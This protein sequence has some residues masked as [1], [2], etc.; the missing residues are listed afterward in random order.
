MTYTETDVL[1]HLAHSDGDK[2]QHDHLIDESV[3]RDAAA[4]TGVPI[5]DVRVIFEYAREAMGHKS[6]R[7]ALDIRD[8]LA[9]ILAAPNPVNAAW[10]IGFAMG[11]DACEG[12]SIDDVATEL[13]KKD[14]PV[15]RAGISKAAQEFGTMFNLPTSRYQRGEAA[16]DA[17]AESATKVHHAKDDATRPRQLPKQIPQNLFAALVERGVS[18]TPTSMNIPDDANDET[19]EMCWGLVGFIQR[20]NQW[21]I[22]D[23]ARATKERRRETWEKYADRVGI[24]PH[25]AEQLAYVSEAV[26]ASVRTEALTFAHHERVAP[27]LPDQQRHWLQQAV[28]HNLTVRQLRNSIKAGKIVLATRVAPHGIDSIESWTGALMVNWERNIFNKR[29]DK[30][31][32]ETLVRWLDKLRKPHQMYESIY[33]RIHNKKP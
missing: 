24:A 27:L 9:F 19:L 32:K 16:Q 22:G 15:T 5:D 13:I 14:L 18:F 2:Q 11:L 23:T 31:P 30:A 29:F 33:M 25:Y 8:G 21:F 6:G 17:Y 1:D 3:L 4:E 28:E 12:R 20:T 7:D 26:D 10:G